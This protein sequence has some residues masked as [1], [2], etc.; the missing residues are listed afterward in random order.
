MALW[1]H[2]G[3][4]PAEAVVVAV[5]VAGAVLVHDDGGAEAEMGAV[6]AAAENVVDVGAAD[7]A[8]PA[9]ANGLTWGMWT[10][11]GAD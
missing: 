10:A 2:L 6:D 7:E 5:S 9:K 3:S 1:H 8:V 4:L 11:T